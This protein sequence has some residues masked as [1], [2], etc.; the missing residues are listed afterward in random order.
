VVLRCVDYL[1]RG[2]VVLSRLSGLEPYKD[3]E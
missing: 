1:S 3:T 2:L